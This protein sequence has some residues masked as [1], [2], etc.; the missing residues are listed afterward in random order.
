MTASALHP[1]T[2]ALIDKAAAAL[3][4][5][6]DPIVVLDLD[7]TLYDASS[8]SLR[9]FQE[10]AHRH[11]RSHPELLA[12]LDR[13]TA[14][15]VA[16]GLVETLAGVGVEEGPLLAE[17]KTFWKERFF[18][19]EYLH[20]DLPT[21]GAVEF[22]NTLYTHGMV[23]TYLTGRDAP[24]MLL[25]TLS[26]LQ[27]DG[28]PVGTVDARAILKGNAATP[29][30]DYKAS[31]ITHLRATGEVIGSFDN[32]PGLCNLFAEA[33]PEAVVV[34]LDQP[35]APG[36]PPLSARVQTTKDFVPLVA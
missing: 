23:P 6:R 34:W 11:A 24:N 21:A 9:I 28:F 26:T 19:N 5:G 33:F 30:H 2:R 31:V 22:V 36:A 29:D 12:A 8:R 1:I 32:E 13:M 7:G 18:T 15:E 14:Q 20:F 17:M 25:G 10:Y 3:S 35:H 4:R 27:R 16:Y